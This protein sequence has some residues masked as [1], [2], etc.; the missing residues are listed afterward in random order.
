MHAAVV[1]AVHHEGSAPH[2][3]PDSMNRRKSA[4]GW[5][6]GSSAYSGFCVLLPPRIMPTAAYA[7]SMRSL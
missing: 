3:E 2:D 6:H 1:R 7:S 5:H 4:A